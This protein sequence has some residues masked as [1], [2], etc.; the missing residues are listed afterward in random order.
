MSKTCPKCGN[1]LDDKALACDKCGLSLELDR[2]PAPVTP[3]PFGAPI[4]AP[5]I[6]KNKKK[7]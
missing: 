4:P 3:P 1:K 2:G 5:A 7:K 6:P